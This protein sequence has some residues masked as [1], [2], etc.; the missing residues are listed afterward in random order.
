V[1]LHDS[2]QEQG[3]YEQHRDKREEYEAKRK[4]PFKVA[5]PEE[6]QIAE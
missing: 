1:S 2:L 4:V 3:T 5:N 6:D